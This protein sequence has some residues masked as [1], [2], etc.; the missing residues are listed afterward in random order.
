MSTLC[1]RIP[2]ELDHT[3][4][5]FAAQEERTKTFIVRKAIEQYLEDLYDYNLAEEGYKRYI[6]SGKKSYDLKT[7]AKRLKIDL[8]KD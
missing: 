1:I 6:E 8:D 2:D 7:V 5:L 4:E 3:L